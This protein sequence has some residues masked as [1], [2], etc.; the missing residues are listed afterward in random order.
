MPGNIPGKAL[1]NAISQSTSNSPL[2][3]QIAIDAHQIG[4]RRTGAETYVYNLV[5]NLALLEP[6]GDKYAVYLSSGQGVEG[7]ES[8][9]SFEGRSIPS[10][11]PPVRYAFFYP[12]QSWIKRFDIFH[13]QFSLPPL[14]RSRSV[15]TVYDLCYERFPQF[16]NRRVLAQ[17]KLLM[18]WSCQRADHI[19]TISESSKRDLVEIYRLDPQKIT[20]T[21]P[22]PAENCKPMDAGQAKDRLR[23]AYG[24]DGSFILYVGNLEPRKN[25]PRLLEAFAQLKQK[26]LIVHKLVIVGQ[27]AWLYNGILETMRN[28]S[29]SGEVVLTGYIPANDLPL[30]YNAASF[31][32]YPSLYEGFGLPV[33]EAMACGTPVITSLGSSLEEIAEGAA[34]LVDPYSVASIATAIEKVANDL[35]LQQD[36]RNAASARAARFSFR[37][38]A[39]QTRS[40]YH[41]L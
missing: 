12:F 25:L 27:K 29:L 26:E 38:M 20:V 1:L 8:N 22:G 30:F 37:K 4:G 41:R 19:I 35:N 28:H 24:I 13:A 14:L 6:N 2:S 21:Y 15:L 17:M 5:K 16:F 23:E 7:L 9:P 3:M 39:E 40:V 11:I 36:L 32:I 18:P 34:L 10:S 31:M 33:V